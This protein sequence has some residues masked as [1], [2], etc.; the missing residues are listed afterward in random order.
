VEMGVGGER[1]NT[2]GHHVVAHDDRDRRR[3]ERCAI[4]SYHEVGLIDFDDLGVDRR[5]VGGIA[6]VVIEIEHDGS[7]EKAAACVD[8]VA[9]KLDRG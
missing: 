8:I 4:G 9:P 6:L 7:A 3:D 5:H 2:D 1:E